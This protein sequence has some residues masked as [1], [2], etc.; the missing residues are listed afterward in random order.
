MLWA[1]PMYQGTISK[2]KKNALDYTVSPPQDSTEKPKSY[3]DN[4]RYDRVP[5]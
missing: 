4:F 5:S 2:A 3:A 1:S